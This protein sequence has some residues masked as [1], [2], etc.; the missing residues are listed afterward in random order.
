MNFFL[1][2]LGAAV[3]P[4][5]ILK[6]S[7]DFADCSHPNKLNLGVGIYFDNQARSFVLKAV[8]RAEQRVIKKKERNQNYIP[9]SGLDIFLETSRDLVFEDLSLSVA[10][11]ATAGGTQALSLGAKMIKKGFSSR[12]AIIGSPAWPNHFQIFES[13]GFEVKTYPNLRNQRADEEALFAALEKAPPGSTVL[14]QSGQANNPSGVNFSAWSQI[15]DLMSRKRFLAF[16]DCAYAGFAH[17]VSEDTEE[18][19]YFAERGI[20][21]VVA[22]SY[23]KN[24]SLYKQR[25][26]ALLIPAEN[27]KQVDLLTSHMRR[28]VRVENSMP[29][30]HGQEIAVEIFSDLAL[31][32]E[33]LSEL[34]QLRDN[35][36]SRRKNLAKLAGEKFDFLSRQKGL[37][38]ILDISSEQIDF[39]RERYGIFL[40]GNGRINFGGLPD[41]K[42]EYLGRALRSL[43]YS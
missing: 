17:S 24:M 40:V 20:P 22:F 13:L 26:G 1:K 18:I 25:T 19:R 10:A 23:S 6:I 34:S 15:A 29:P 37:F 4:D 16:F 2:D 36:D 8:K 28:F 11:Q 38:S 3:P 14:F 7:K 12:V 43:N 42:Q 5:K 33:W 35:L 41:D 21:T 32:K 27:K 39:L 30:A 9:A 31:R